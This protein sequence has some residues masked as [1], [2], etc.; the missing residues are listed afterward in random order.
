MAIQ[1]RGLDAPRAARQRGPFGQLH[2]EDTG[3]RHLALQC[4][5]GDVAGQVAAVGHLQTHPPQVGAQRLGRGRQQLQPGQRQRDLLQPG[6][7]ARCLALAQGR[8]R[9][10]PVVHV[11]LTTPR[12]LLKLS[13]TRFKLGYSGSMKFITVIVG[14]LFY[15]ISLP[16]WN[17]SY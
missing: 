2:L 14:T 3:P 10:A 9:I 16:G 17:L 11:N 6:R 4:P 15:D 1:L 12:V 7:E 8:R 13:K 5:P